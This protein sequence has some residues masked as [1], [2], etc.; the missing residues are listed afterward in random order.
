MTLAEL[1]PAIFL[2]ITA[3]SLAGL[4]QAYSGP[5]AYRPLRRHRCWSPGADH[6]H[7]RRLRLAPSHKYSGGHREGFLS[8]L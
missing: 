7:P 6:L 8:G 1:E 2:P 3:V 4:Q 5:T